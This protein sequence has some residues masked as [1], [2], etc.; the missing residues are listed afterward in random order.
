MSETIDSLL[1]SL[2]LETDK[3]SFDQANAAFKSVTDGVLQLAAATGVGFGVKALTA[4][5]ADSALEMKRLSDNTGFTIRQIQG[6]EFAMRRLRLSPDAAHDIA[7]KIP[8]LQ[9]KARTGEL[10]EKAYWGAAF[11]PTDFSRMKPEDAFKYLIS[12]YSGMNNDQRAF[13]SDG[14]QLG[15]DSPITRLME[16][17]PEFFDETME[18]SNQLEYPIDESLLNSAQEFND[19]MAV[20][21]RNFEILSYQ[22]GG[23]LLSSLNKL[24]GEIN[25][26]VDKHRETINTVTDKV[27]TGAWYDDIMD[28]AEV[29][30]INFRNH[31]RGNDAILSLILGKEEKIP[32]RLP[33]VPSTIKSQEPKPIQR[34]QSAHKPTASV[35]DMEQY[36]NDPNVLHYLDVIA[37]AEGT[38]KYPNSGYNTKFGGGQFSD[39]AD[40]P[41]ELMSFK[42]TDGKNNLT[43]A[44]GRYQFTRQ[45]WDSAANALG[46][47]DFSPESQ[48]LAA[49][50]LINRRGQLDNVANG[51]FSSATAGLGNEWASLPS[52]RYAQPTRSPEEMEGYYSRRN[53]PPEPQRHSGS[54]SGT[55]TKITLAPVITINEAG[56]AEKTRAIVEECLGDACNELALSVRT[57]SQ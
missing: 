34:G 45:T 32:S 29:S 10:G 9:R 44:A 7:K 43:S 18:K 13:L 51:D 6:L 26:F 57:N 37:K 42:Q 36:L 41:R 17:G 54:A 21:G 39:N 56:D 19:Q 55:P 28:H 30:G 50:Y 22:M 4:G 52:S 1:V 3:K 38:D 49:I 2:G 5:V 15:R 12:S 31:L 40:H 16:M 33:T 23:P 8:E 25:G 53:T 48:D 35:R 20:L 24:L 27:I 14:A 46:L 11:N 47:T